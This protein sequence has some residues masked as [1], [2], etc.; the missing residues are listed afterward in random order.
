MRGRAIRRH[1]MAVAKARARRVVVEWDLP[2]E[3]GWIGLLARTP[4][5]CSC[6]MCGNPRRYWRELRRQELLANSDPQFAC[7]CEEV[8]S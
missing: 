7:D 1:H 5:R 2:L 4:A 3:P 6:W 8:R